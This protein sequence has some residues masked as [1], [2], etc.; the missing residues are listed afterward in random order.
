[1]IGRFR[2]SDRDEAHRL[3]T[4]SYGP[5]RIL[6]PRAGSSLDFELWWTEQKSSRIGYS[7]YGT[8]VR[9]EAPPLES[10]YVVCFPTKG[11]IA[12]SSGGASMRTSVP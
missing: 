3:L 1:V 5:N 9:I 4:G 8:D 7:R 10:W 6:V 11:R 2:T 12:V